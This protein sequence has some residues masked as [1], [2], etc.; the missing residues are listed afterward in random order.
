M[1]KFSVSLEK[2]NNQ[3][4]IDLIQVA[5]LFC[6]S[7]VYGFANIST[8]VFCGFSSGIKFA[9][10]PLRYKLVAFSFLISISLLQWS[11]DTLGNSILMYG[12][13]GIL[14][15]FIFNYIPH[16]SFL[17]KIPEVICIVSIIFFVPVVASFSK[18]NADTRGL[19]IGGKWARVITESQN[20]EVLTSN[21]QYSYNEFK[22]RLEAQIITPEDK[23]SKFKEIYIITPTKPFTSENK[24]KLLEWTAS[25]GKLFIAADHTNL[26]GHQ[27]VLENILN[28]FGISI[29]PD[30]VF[31]Q[32]TN[33]G[34][35]ENFF[36]SL[37]GLTPC[38]I[39]NGVIPRLW[40]AGFSE[41]P[42]YTA[43]SFFGQLSPSNDDIRGY[44]VIMG[45]R[46][47]GLG[48]VSV[49]TDST[50]FA[51]F[52]INRW[53]SAVVLNSL[54]W[55]LKATIFLMAGVII[56]FLSQNIKKFSVGLSLGLFL[57]LIAPFLGFQAKAS[58]KSDFS[59]ILKPSSHPSATNSEDREKGQGCSVLAS[60]YGLGVRVGWSDASNKTFI[61]NLSKGIPI[62]NPKLSDS[63][64][65]SSLTE[66]DYGA[67]ID[68][69]FYIDNNSFWFSQGA[70]PVRTSNMS[71]FWQSAGADF[72]TVTAPQILLQSTIM[73]RIGEGTPKP[74]ELIHLENNWAIVDNKIVARWVPEAKKWLIRK[75][76]QF[77]DYFK[78]DLVLTPCSP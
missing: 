37:S 39:Q 5:L 33:G 77:G 8:P 27:T 66:F 56:F 70:G 22:S 18:S 65:F 31:E 64:D 20:N 3:N 26:F 19:L 32:K 54:F 29:N 43:P 57:I 58:N 45:S 67:I 25:G 55:P 15:S 49:F 63:S 47:Y 4:I 78:N 7:I 71:N 69:H 68:G 10:N 36:N 21:S 46:R 41:E 38:S 14:G 52:A 24:K 74:Y 16:I 51:N 30:S 72:K 23:F 34:T 73:G 61:E 40:M 9:K 60:A 75:E 12:I 2:S 44:H 53:S 59:I 17:R 48:E 62:K 50:F 6:I 13:G 1:R 35:Y 28:D 76:W 42:D 11:T